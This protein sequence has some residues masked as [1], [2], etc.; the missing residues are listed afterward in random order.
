MQRPS[1]RARCAPGVVTDEPQSAPR[2]RLHAFARAG[3]VA[4]LRARTVGHDD[5]LVRAVLCAFD[6]DEPGPPRVTAQLGAGEIDDLHA[7]PDRH[8]RLLSGS[9]EQRF[10][11]YAAMQA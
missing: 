9:A 11:E 6:I 4:K 3:V 7:R 5:Q 10:E 2:V 1:L 8:A